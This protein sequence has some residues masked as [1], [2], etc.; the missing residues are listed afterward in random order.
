[1]RRL[2]E[3]LSRKSKSHASHE[4]VGAN[5]ALDLD[6]SHIAPPAISAVAPQ[7]STAT[8]RDAPGPAP[9]PNGF[10]SDETPAHAGS[11]RVLHN[12]KR[13]P[14]VLESIE[15]SATVKWYKLDASAHADDTRT[16]RSMSLDT[17]M[18][19]HKHK[20]KHVTGSAS[21]TRVVRT[22]HAQTS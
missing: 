19:K 14:F 15:Y 10:T 20:H 22:R 13:T 2:R 6:P 4:N 8:S 1:M 7:T 11:R 18:H 21:A 3:R 16:V 17:C 12:N 5:N 9:G